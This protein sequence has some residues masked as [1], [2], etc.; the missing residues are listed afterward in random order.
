MVKKTKLELAEMW[1]KN[2]NIC[3]HCPWFHKHTTYYNLKVEQ[4][5]KMAKYI[6]KKHLSKDVN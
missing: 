2:N 1:A 3:G 5:L 4:I 6:V